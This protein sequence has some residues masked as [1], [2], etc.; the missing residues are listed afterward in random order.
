MTP[1]IKVKPKKDC[2]EHHVRL[3]TTFELTFKE[4]VE[5]VALALACSGFLVKV[6]WQSAPPYVIEVYTDRV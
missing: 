1:R 3:H 2:P 6:R 4:N 5:R